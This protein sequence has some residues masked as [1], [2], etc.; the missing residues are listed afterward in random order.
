M[1]AAQ[2]DYNNATATYDKEF[3]Q[4]LQMINLLQNFEDRAKADTQR[5]SNN[6]R[7]NLQII[8]NQAKSGGLEYDEMPDQQKLLIS[9]L[10]Y[11]AGLPAGFIQQL[12]NK[13]SG[14]IVS[15]S[16]RTDASG[17]K[18]T[19]I[20]MQDENGS[21]NVESMFLGKERIPKSS[22]PKQTSN[23]LSKEEQEF[24]KSA[25]EEVNKLING[26]RTYEESQNYLKSA[27]G[28]PDNIIDQYIGNFKD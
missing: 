6:A 27:W 23:T 9:K 12:K 10:E 22:M 5:A 25:R 14:K 26:E 28:A 13:N 8:Y 15:Y 2:L 20:V 19:D 16:N 3:N 24:I 1:D 17:S 21:L 7:A 11:Q 18:F 4:N